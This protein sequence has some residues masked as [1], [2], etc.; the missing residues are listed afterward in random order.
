MGRIVHLHLE[1][2]LHTQN[3]GVRL[4][5]DRCVHIQQVECFQIHLD[6]CIHKPM[7]ASLKS[8]STNVIICKWIDVFVHNSIHES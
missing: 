1:R 3:G 2:H 7:E 4:R 5:V 6:R 8:Q